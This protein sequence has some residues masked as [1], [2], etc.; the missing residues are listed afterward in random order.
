MTARNLCPSDDPWTVV[1]SKRCVIS[2]AP[3]AVI[4]SALLPEA[5]VATWPVSEQVKH[6]RCS[7]P[8]V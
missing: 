7:S 3:W 1:S 2:V 8:G 5:W 4:H 6:G